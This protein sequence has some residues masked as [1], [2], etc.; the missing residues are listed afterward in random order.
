M[1]KLNSETAEK[2]DAVKDGFEPLEEGVYVLQ[3]LE[4]VEVKE[5]PKGIYWKWT[6]VV[7]EEHDGEKLEN[8]GRKI[9]TNTSLKETAFFKLKETFAAFGVATD[10]DT[11]DLV[12]KR[13]KAMIVQEA[14]GAG[15]R[16]GEIGNQIQKL[17]PLDYDENAAEEKADA[18]AKGGDNSE[19]MF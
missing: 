16:K 6:F 14:I 18:L 17:F 13:V 10:T 2:V 11:E 19:P 15:A 1:P 7:P 5:G 3:L 12:G 9:F 4:D 8:A